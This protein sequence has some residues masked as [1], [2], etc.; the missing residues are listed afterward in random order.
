[1]PGMPPPYQ[2]R[3][4]LSFSKEW[5]GYSDDFGLVGIPLGSLLIAIGCGLPLI[6]LSGAFVERIDWNLK[7]LVGLVI[8]FG[9]CLIFAACGF[10]MLI[11]N[12]TWV[13]IKQSSTTVWKVGGP[14]GLSRRSVELNRSEQ[15]QVC[16][17]KDPWVMFSGSYAVAVAN[18]S[19][20]SIE[21][22]H[23]ATYDLAWSMRK[24][25]NEVLGVSSI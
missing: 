22:C 1:M 21:I 9:L 6:V 18:D 7:T 3:K 23:A 16:Q 8:A 12:R 25:I 17:T 4:L 2:S 11:W 19:G 10:R 15:L 13:N 24:E 5:V 20:D 14:F